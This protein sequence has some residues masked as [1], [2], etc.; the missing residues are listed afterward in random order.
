MQQ[1]LKE[2]K[3]YKRCIESYNALKDF[4]NGH[5][6]DYE[7]C[8]AKDKMEVIIHPCLG[9]SLQMLLKDVRQA[10][11]YSNGELHDYLIS[12]EDALEDYED[13]MF[14]QMNLIV[15]EFHD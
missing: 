11:F 9:T 14:H 8:F 6:D 13:E 1:V 15:D 7:D 2:T 3:I 10:L 5:K 4:W 12:F